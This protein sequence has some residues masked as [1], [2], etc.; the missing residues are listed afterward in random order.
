MST[1]AFD[2]AAVRARFSALDRPTAFFDAPGG[3]QAPDSVIDAMAGY[4]RESNANLGGPFE[5]SRRSDALVVVGPP[6]RR[7]LPRLRSRRGRLR[8]EHDDAQLRAHA[9]AG[10]RAPRRRRDRGHAARPRRQHLAL[11]P[12]GGRPRP[13]G[14]LRRPER[15]R[16]HA[17]H[18]RPGAPT[19]R[20]HAGGRLPLGLERGRDRHRCPQDRR[21]RARR[22]TRS[23]GSTPSTTRRTARSTCAIWA[24]TYC[25][26]RRTNFSARISASSTAAATCSSACVPTRCD[27][28]RTS[29]SSSRFETG[30]L[31]HEA[32]A[33]FNAAVAYIESV[34][35][36]G[37]AAHERELGRT[38]PGRAPGRAP[39]ATARRRWRGGWRPSPSRSPGLTPEQAATRLAERGL[40][41]WCGRLLRG[42]GDGAPGPAG[43][44][45]PPRDHPLQ[46]RRGGRP[47]LAALH[48][49]VSMLRLYWARNDG[50]EGHVFLGLEDLE[51]LAAE[52]DEQGMSGWL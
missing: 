47:P 40:A 25:S 33:G 15:G 23:P 51:P 31:P 26:A 2:V 35:W 1:V 42:R 36:E 37:I 32:L 22:W 30:T 49:L 39:P 50:I 45:P 17:R 9:H 44:R 5:T 12:A 6:Y 8:P 11:A 7:A 46:H 19:E 27:R 10:P 28:P 41:V 48:D 21:A 52:M 43:R 20:A 29:P 38:A 24:R 4:L 34:G 13:D 18:G 14:S 16:R 3:T